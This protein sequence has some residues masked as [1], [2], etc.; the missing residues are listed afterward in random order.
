MSALASHYRIALQSG[1]VGLPEVKLG[2]LPGAG[3]TQRVPRLA[4][5]E[6]TL[7]LI[8]SGTPV[9]ADRA[10]ARATGCGE[11]DGCRMG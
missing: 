5:I 7:D 4:S 1:K 11:Y 6:A 2:L 8:L 3:G 10:A 9:G